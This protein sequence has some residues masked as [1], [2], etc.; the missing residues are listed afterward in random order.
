MRS[1][2]LPKRDA[3]ATANLVSNTKKRSGSE[4]AESGL[5]AYLSRVLSR[6][7]RLNKKKRL[8]RG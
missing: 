3:S 5:D 2:A 8:L 4:P 6:I 1:G 7:L